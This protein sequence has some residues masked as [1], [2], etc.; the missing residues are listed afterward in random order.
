MHKTLYLIYCDNNGNIQVRK[1]RHFEN[2][3]FFS[4]ESFYRYFEKMGFKD[5]TLK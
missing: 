1:W 5:I 2:V 3:A 4:K